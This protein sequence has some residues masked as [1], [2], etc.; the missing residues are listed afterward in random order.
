MILKEI[1]VIDA[2]LHADE[3]QY[4]L[5]RGSKQENLWGVNFY[6]EKTAMILSSSIQ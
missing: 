2:E 3:E 1:M 4:L 6:P 5:Q